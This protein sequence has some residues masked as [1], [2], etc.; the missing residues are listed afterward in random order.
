MPKKKDPKDP[1]NLPPKPEGDTSANE[2]A[3][4]GPPPTWNPGKATQPPAEEE[5]E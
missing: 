4:G 3:N 5:Q 2:G 1:K